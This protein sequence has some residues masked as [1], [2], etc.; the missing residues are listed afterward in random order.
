M[1]NTS[2]EK[3]WIVYITTYPPRECG[4]AT[5][6]A[7]LVESF[8]ELFVPR[9]ETKVIAMAAEGFSP[10]TYPDKVISQISENNPTDYFEAAK[11]L[12][13]MSQ[14]KL[15]SIQHE[16]GIFGG[17]DGENILLFLDEIKRPVA[18]TF[19]TVLP[20]PTDHQKMLVHRMIERADRVIVM[21]HSSK[22]ILESVYAAPH[23]KVR[24]IPHGIHPCAFTNGISAKQTLGFAGKKII[25]TFGLLNRGKGIE[26]AIDALPEI[27]KKYPDVLYV[28]VG[29]TH[30]VV[31]KREGPV[32]VQQLKEQ[33]HRLGVEDHVVF[34]DK[35][36]ETNELLKFLQA[37]D[38]YLS[39]SQNPDQAV[40]GTLTYALGMG[41][42]VVSTPFMQAREVVTAETG[43]LVD[44]NDHTSISNA[45][46]S[47]FEDPERLAKMSKTAYFR[48]RSMTWQ[49]VALSYMRDFKTLSPEL[50]KKEKSLPPIDLQHMR[51]MTD[52]FGMF[53]F[54]RLQEPDPQS[55]YTID[56]NARALVAACWFAHLLRDEDIYTLADVYLGFLETAAKEGGGFENYFNVDRVPNTERNSNE[57]LEDADARASWSL[58][59][60]ATSGAPSSLQERAK[61]I[62]KRQYETRKEITSPRAMAFHIKAIALW[63]KIEQDE[64]MKR[65]LSTYADFL[66]EL[67]HLN[68]ASDWQWFEEGLAYSNA[69][70]PEALLVAYK[71]T[72]NSDY[73]KIGSATLEFLISH[74]YEGELCVPVGQAGWFKRGG[75]KHLYDQQ[76]EEVSA[77]VLA[78]RT[79]FEIDGDHY[80]LKRIEQAFN[81]F[82]GNNILGQ[83]VYSHMTGGSYD[84]LGE[85]H[86]N[87]NQGAES[88]ISYLLA[89]VIMESKV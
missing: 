29:A 2:R 11:M 4:I 34:F 15:V 17:H 51:R 58:A 14:V 45:V 79:M 46:I 21:T 62:F 5:F 39:L 47:L 30:P 78:L 38:I 52:D 43:V 10:Q 23:E 35:Y 26:H 88:T 7:D 27:V 48:T 89:R 59:V 82:L 20:H 6:S 64:D 73:L 69:V 77:L 8:D 40:S 19:H 22:Q 13:D 25:S 61:A 42:P 85:D 57:N 28:V 36:V 80:F 33:A 32:Y 67:Y 70:L 37:T 1:E 63:L 24:V 54:A 55:G 71:V 86:V 74:S 41:R 53:Q 56:D 31:L 18:I 87:L 16:F 81:W 65:Q 72:G 12:N 3:M 66:V 83:V 49:N 84:G 50:A 44:F 76:P 60:A 68:Q 75:E 9:E